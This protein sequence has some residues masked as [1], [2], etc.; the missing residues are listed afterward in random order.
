MTTILMANHSPIK[1]ALVTGASK[2]LGKEIVRRF[3]SAGIY[4]LATARSVEKLNELQEEFPDHVITFPGDIS[5]SNHVK[6]LVDQVIHSFGRL[7]FVINN[8]GLAHFAPV[9]DLT[10]NQWDEM[11]SVNLKAA[12]LACKY[13][14]PHLKKT[15]GH[16]VNISSVAGTEAFARGA[17][18]CASKFGMMALSDAL[19]QE[20]KPHY[21]KV[22]TLCPGSIQTEFSSNPKSYSLH[23]SDVA[24]SVYQIITAPANMIIGRVIMRPVVP[25]DFQKK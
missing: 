23:A 16:I 8:A 2:G 14:I 17:G 21:V 24:E 15:Q 22:S 12:F 6:N 3:A 7:D 4:V 1:A 25:V 5:D 11:M 19:T 18:Y 13:A 9:E 10:E 20:L